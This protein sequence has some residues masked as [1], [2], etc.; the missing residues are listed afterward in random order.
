MHGTCAGCCSADVRVDVAPEPLLCLQTGGLGTY[1]YMAPEV[2][3]HQRYS[4]KVLSIC[5]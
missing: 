2:L 5:P 3:G 4:E 1:E